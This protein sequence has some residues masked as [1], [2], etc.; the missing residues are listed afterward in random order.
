VGL[1]D[2]IIDSAAVGHAYQST[3]NRILVKTILRYIVFW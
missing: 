1:E 2:G 3:V